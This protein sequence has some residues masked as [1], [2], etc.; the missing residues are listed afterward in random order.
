MKSIYILSSLLLLCLA[1]P[2]QAQQNLVTGTIT[3]TNGEPLIGASV[4]VENDQQR[5]LNGTISDAN[6]NY[7]LAIPP[8]ENLNIVF[9]YIGFT[10]KR[11]AYSSQTKLNINLE[12][13]AFE[14]G[15][16]EVVAERVE[17][18]SLGISAR[19]QVA[20]SQRFDVEQ[21]EEVPMTSIESG[22]Q[23]RMANVDII[24]GADPGSRSSIRIRGT[25]S[26][27]ANSEP[28][29][30][31]D[32]VPYPTNFGDDFNFATANDQDFGALVNISPNDIESIE[33][34]KDAAATAIWGSQGANGVLVFK[35][36]KGK[37][38][39]TRFSFS[40]KSEVKKEPS[41]IPMLNGAQYVSLM[42][43]GIWNS[44]NDI[45]YQSGAA[46]TGLLFGTQEINFDPEWVYF[47]E[48][49]QDTDWVDEVT[50]LGYFLDNNFSLS[51]GGDKAIYRVSVGY[52]RDVGTTIG[53]S[54]DRFNSLASVTYKFSNKLSVSADMSYSQ[55]LK[56]ANWTESNFP[57]ARSM[58]MFKMPNMSPYVLDQAGNRTTEYFT[59]LQNFQGS[60]GSNVYNPVALVNESS[61]QTK[62]D[63]S[64]V[65]FRL[66][67]Q[68]NPDFQYLGT[69]GF[70]ARTT[71][72]KKFLPQSATGVLW[73]DPYFNRSSD[74][75]SDQLYINTENK[76][77]YNKALN[78]RNHI[79][80]SGLLQ[81]NESRS[82]GY[83]SETSGNAS[84][85]LSDPTD[86]AAVA[87][88]KSDNSMS[89]RIS[90]ITNG[91]YTFNG[92]YI[93][94]GGYR[95]EAN[96]SL[97]ASNRWAGFPSLGLAWQFGDEPFMNGIAGIELGK[98]RASWGKS[99]NPPGGAWP[100]I[101]TFSPITP[102]Y[103]DM[104]AISPNS[105]QLE[106]LK[107]ETITQ[108]NIGID[109]S[110]LNGKLFLTA[111]VYDRKTTDL[112][113]KN[114]SLPSSTGFS[115]V[116]YYNSGEVYNRGWELIF[117]YDAVRRED[118]GLSFNINFAR[119]RNEVVEL[120]DNM[121]FE[122]YTFGNEKYA[123]KIVEGNPIGSFYGYRY[124]GV[125]QNGEET[126]AHDGDGKLMYDIEGDL[127]YTKNGN[128][129][130]FPGDAKYEDINGDGVIDQY[131]I[132]YLGNAMP[133]FTAGGGFNLRWK[134]FM[135]TTFVH[136]RFGQK[137]VNQARMQTENMYG[138]A[139]QSTAVLKRW[140]H[141]GD[142][143][144]IPRALYNEG[145]NFLGSDRY[146]E[147][148]S[149]I[150]LKTVS[151]RYSL[152][153]AFL[154]KNK[155]ERFDIFFTAQDLYT[156]TNYSGQDP[157]VSLSSN[158]YMLSVDNARTPRPRRYALGINMNF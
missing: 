146:V 144:E 107:W 23:G 158:I 51:G 41:T 121:L 106:N 151:L 35:T 92:K 7:R 113:Q 22:L 13:E 111:E 96:S 112:L 100:Y 50:Q 59:P 154:S 124:L 135:L 133:V 145:Y 153:K 120:P 43:D 122:N 128:R 117:N 157:E 31:V 109:L 53:T 34:L 101:G 75:L 102:G 155:I 17:V 147:D 149:F 143:T 45:G 63:N 12:E 87:S 94:S 6:G 84:S 8:M 57:S 90:A 42:Q 110:L 20:A 62:A 25:S 148:G 11:L 18:N 58:A 16:A 93:I 5:N 137:I 39:K 2:L 127:V 85:A 29:I 52:L 77:I 71:K 14:Y 91:H 61:N 10:T 67:Y 83:V 98:L 54:L 142:D 114:Y 21:L 38:G 88:M 56:D 136:G 3:D 15:S 33:V 141:E 118:W 49:N 70:D 130:V 68:F 28:L 74:L 46:Y 78:D 126:Y 27:N 138:T 152:P 131:D 134:N 40:T 30:V 99:G 48:Y 24:S 76:L 115:Q 140:R 72:N 81:T 73:T 103:M 104:I 116:G 1:F 82:F 4:F 60:F 105:I 47:D 125:Y 19:E 55:S 37:K 132:V 95:W 65:I 26:L 9:S 108:S 89:R 86:G 64:R 44:V 156:W 123:H 129:R 66:K 119:N 139:N 36:K 32:G 150:R 79:I 69:V 80:L 97:G